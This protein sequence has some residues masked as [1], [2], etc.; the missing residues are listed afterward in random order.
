MHITSDFP[1]GNILVEEIAGDTVRLRQDLRDTDGDW[2]YW[3]F[4]VS[5]AAGRTVRF[6]FT[7]SPAV[8]ARGPAWSADDGATWDWLGLT[9]NRNRFVFFFPENA[10]T[11]RFC[12]TIPY[13]AKDW[14][15]FLARHAGRGNVRP[16]RLCDS[17]KGRTVDLL[18]MGVPDRAPRFRVALTARHHSCETM[19]SFALEG[20][21]EYVL[22]AGETEA[23]WLRENVEL[24]AVPFL[25]KDGVEDGDQGKNRRPHDHNRDY[26]SD[27]L[28]PETA[29]VKA[30]LSAASVPFD[31]ALD[32]HCP[33]L[34]GGLNEAVYLVGAR[35]PAIWKEQQE[36]AAILERTRRG[37]LPVLAADNLPFGQEWNVAES[38]AKGIPFGDWA[39]R[40]PGIRLAASLEVPYAN[41]RGEEV[42]ASSARALGAD[43]GRALALYL[44]H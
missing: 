7:G 6:E 8:G 33:W 25:D 36:F 17:R 2:F 44:R 20:L 12:M 18:T 29:A 41:A 4:A 34:C 38:F 11:V 42:N 9:E 14:E 15:K 27:S 26:G 21:L 16:G 13:V 5:G 31:V 28:Y 3:Y 24:V 43:F 19:G 22:S 37:P 1:G 35:E 39:G 32:L 40:N 30:L 23:A 10:E